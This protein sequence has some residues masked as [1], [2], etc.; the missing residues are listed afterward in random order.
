M[1][2]AVKP[3]GFRLDP[4]ETASVSGDVT[5]GWIEFETGAGRGYGHVR[6]KDG[7]IWTLLTTL[8]ELKGFEEPK[9]VRRPMGAEHGHGRTLLGEATRRAGA[10]P[11]CC[12]GDHCHPSVETTHRVRPLVCCCW[13]SRQSS[14]AAIRAAQASRS[15]V[16]AYL[17]RGQKKPRSP[18][19]L[20]RGTTWQ[21]RWGTVSPPSKPL[22]ITSR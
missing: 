3:K 20:V 5:E 9:G 15:S 14:A 16:S 22:L 18:S 10:D 7:R 2:A 6:L 1:I 17:V 12:S 11:A 19:P 8:V 21:C 13:G 4:A